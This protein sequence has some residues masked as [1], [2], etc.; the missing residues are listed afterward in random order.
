[1]GAV[2]W[3]D[4]AARNL[5]WNLAALRARQGRSSR[6]AFSG[7]DVPA[8]GQDRGPFHRHVPI[9]QPFCGI[10]PGIRLFLRRFQRPNT[11]SLP[12]VA[13]AR[14]GGTMPPRCARFRRCARWAAQSARGLADFLTPLQRRPVPGRGRAPARVGGCRFA[15]QRRSGASDERPKATGLADF[16]TP[17]QALMRPRPGLTQS[18][19][20]QPFQALSLR[21]VLA[22]PT[23]PPI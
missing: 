14:A 21:S 17:L 22:G 23:P 6:P 8:T 13:R 7:F 16:L 3:A 20:R 10:L 18:F 5:W 12:A 19:K 11:A 2:Q 15:A 9:C 1:M 4:D